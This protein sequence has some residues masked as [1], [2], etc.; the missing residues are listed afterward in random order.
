MLDFA[1]VKNEGEGN[2]SYFPPFAKGEVHLFDSRW[3]KT[4][5][6]SWF[7][8]AAQGQ[9]FSSGLEAE[10]FSVIP[11]ASWLFPKS[12]FMAI[13]AQ[14]LKKKKGLSSFI[15]HIFSSLVTGLKYPD[16]SSPSETLSFQTN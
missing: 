1:W 16:L 7:P 9:G 8:P 6:K 13:G 4:P 11:P 14:L 2:S 3:H 5:L 12:Y 15:I 10:S